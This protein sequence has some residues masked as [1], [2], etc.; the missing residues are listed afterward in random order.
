MLVQASDNLRPAA[1]PQLAADGK[2]DIWET[3]GSGSS[4]LGQVCYESPWQGKGWSLTGDCYLAGGSNSSNFGL[5]YY[6]PRGLAFDGSGI[7]WIGSPG[8]GA[9]SNGNPLTPGVVAFGGGSQGNGTDEFFYSS[10]LA[11]GPLRVAVDGSGN[12]WVLLA[13]NTVTEYVGVATP[14][15]TPLA[16]GVKNKKLGAKP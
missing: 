11:A 13:D 7:V 6:N 15:V 14:V 1:F 5:Y 9:D 3:V 16:L 10:S 12:V 2:G 8:G 4:G